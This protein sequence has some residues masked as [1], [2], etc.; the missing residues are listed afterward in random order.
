MAVIQNISV[1]AGDDIEVTFDL[2][3]DTDIDLNGADIKWNVYEQMFGSP[4][5]DP[6]I[7]KSVELGNITV[8]GSPSDIFVVEIDGSDTKDLL[9]NYYHEAY[10]ED[11][12]GN[13]NTITVGIMTLKKTMI[14]RAERTMS[15]HKASRSAFPSS[16]TKTMHASSLQSRKLLFMSMTRGWKATGPWP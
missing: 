3:D 8:P 15:L 16:Q 12:N 2:D 5:G 10:V 13:K 9:H 11:V 1:P 14:G 7:S 6:L 4:Y